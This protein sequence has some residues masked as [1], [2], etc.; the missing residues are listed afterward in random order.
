MRDTATNRFL[1]ATTAILCLLGLGL[2]VAAAQSSAEAWLERLHAE[3]VRAAEVAVVQ[4]MTS[5]DAGLPS[6]PARLE[7]PEPLANSIPPWHHRLSPQAWRLL[8]EHLE[9]EGVPAE[10]LAVAWV[11]SRF[12]AQA[13]SP[14][15]ARGVWQLMPATARRY[16]LAVSAERDDRTDL[17]RSTRAAARYLA[18]LHRQFGDWLLAL[19]AYNAGAER[20]DTAIARA[21]NR[22]FWQVR[23]WLPAETRDYVP[24]V[25]AAMGSPPAAIAEGDELPHSGSR[26]AGKLLFATIAPPGQSSSGRQSTGS[27]RE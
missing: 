6:S 24:A 23:P 19:A 4:A 16:G 14:K 15:G 8:R 7:E 2:P 10:L 13:L 12:Q 11:E 21:E 17:R 22:N 1:L 9:A 26:P 3:L 27:D 18:E 25:L 20:V 5:P